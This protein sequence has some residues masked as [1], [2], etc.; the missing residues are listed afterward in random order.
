MV[1]SPTRIYPPFTFDLSAI[2][3]TVGDRTVWQSLRL[4]EALL[5]LKLIVRGSGPLALNDENS[6]GQVQNGS[7]DSGAR[8][9]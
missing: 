2:V 9:H 6:R 4:I 7:E 3:Q 1:I 5:G 8:G